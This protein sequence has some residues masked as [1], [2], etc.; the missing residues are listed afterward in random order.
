MKPIACRF[1][2]PAGPAYHVP[3]LGQASFPA[4]VS[5]GGVSAFADT[6]A[7]GYRHL[8]RYCVHRHYAFH[9]VG[10]ETGILTANPL[11]ELVPRAE[12]ADVRSPG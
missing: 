2:H 11:L 4:L 5:S 12:R 1:G 6:G 8:W 7:S 3:E 10:R 9:H